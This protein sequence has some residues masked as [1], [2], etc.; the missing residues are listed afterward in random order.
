MV[1]SKLANDLRSK[2][3]RAAPSSTIRVIANIAASELEDRGPRLAAKTR[4]EFRRQMS[5]SAQ[6]VRAANSAV[7]KQVRALGLKPG[8]G[9]ETGSFYV[10]AL[11]EQIRQLTEIDGIASVAL[12]KRIDLVR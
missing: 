8:G 9:S 10:D 4:E 5:E 2:L 7:L 1:S 11:P 6:G 12:D 3:K